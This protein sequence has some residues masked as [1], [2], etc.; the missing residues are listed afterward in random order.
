MT[1]LRKVLLKRDISLIMLVFYGLGN[2]LGAGIYVLIG[3]VSGIADIYT[4]FSFLLAAF[5]V[6]FTSLTYAELSS[7]FPYSAGEALY[8]KKAF[9]SKYLSIIIGFMI[10]LSGILSS[11]TILHGFYGYVSTFINIPKTLSSISLIIILCIIAIL[12][13]AKSVKFAAVLTCVEI[14][15]LLFILF[16][17]F[18]N[19]NFNEVSMVNFIPDFKISIWYTISIGAFL[20]FYAFIGFEDMVNIAEEVKEPTKTMPKAIIIALIVSTMLYILVTIVSILA[21][22]PSELSKSV[23]PLADVYSK[24]TNKEPILLSFIGM[25]AV[26]NG[27]LVQIIMVSRLFYG[28][29][30]NNWLPKIFSNINEKTRTPIFSTVVASFLVLIF[31]LWLPIVTLASLTSFF[32]FIIFTLMNLS[33]IKIKREVPNP[34][35]VLVYPIWIPIVGV[36]V[37]V[38]LLIIQLFSII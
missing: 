27:A 3:K 8:A 22:N 21:I 33:L 7:R 24:L 25:F 1:K 10:A 35:G 32:I 19:I 13:I 17:G 34:E 4:P 12:G 20:A 11:A 30:E 28:M 23:A 5:I 9:N 31:T 15:G 38:S 29:G 37:N 36:I 14:F 16:I 18:E 2:I 26:I 6:L